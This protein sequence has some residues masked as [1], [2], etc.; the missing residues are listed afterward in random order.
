MSTAESSTGEQPGSLGGGRLEVTPEPVVAPHFVLVCDHACG[1][2]SVGGGRLDLGRR[3]QLVCT[4]KPGAGERRE[5]LRIGAVSLPRS[6]LS[7]VLPGG[8]CAGADLSVGGGSQ[9]M[10]TRAEVV[11][12]HAERAQE[13]LRVVG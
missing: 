11:G 3:C 10:S 13:A 6:G 1:D 12:D 5:S 4:G 2:Q 7:D 9:S 8:V